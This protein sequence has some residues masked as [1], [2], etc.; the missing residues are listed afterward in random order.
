MAEKLVA[1]MVFL[2]AEMKIDPM[3]AETV[4]DLVAARIF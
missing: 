1:R 2:L 3:V 4:V